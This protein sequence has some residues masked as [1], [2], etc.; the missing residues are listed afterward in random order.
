[1]LRDAKEEKSMLTQYKSEKHKHGKR[2]LNMRAHVTSMIQGFE[3][4]SNQGK[5][6]VDNHRQLITE[7][8]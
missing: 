8:D 3:P 5:L 1:M 7:E 6:V 2:L 4:A